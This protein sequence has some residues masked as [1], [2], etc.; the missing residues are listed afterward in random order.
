MNLQD[1]ITVSEEVQ[2]GK[3]VFKGT[4]VPVES[5]FM[6]LE[7]GISLNEFLEDFPGVSKEQAEAV[8]ES[9]VQIFQ[10]SKWKQLNEIIA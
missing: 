2:F 6:H 1:Y 9:A 4:R 5:L 10:S 8:L 3:P 7:Q